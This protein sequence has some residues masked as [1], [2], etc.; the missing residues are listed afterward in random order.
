[1]IALIQRMESD[2]EARDEGQDFGKVSRRSVQVSR[3][4][5]ASFSGLVESIEFNA[6]ASRVLREPSRRLTAALDRFARATSVIDEWDRRLQALGIPV[7]LPT[8]YGSLKTHTPTQMTT[9]AITASQ[10]HSCGLP[11]PQPTTNMRKAPFW[12]Q[13]QRKPATT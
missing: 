4:A 12:A 11:K 1:M 5:M 8:G 13:R 10:T 3:D 9:Q 2:P 7:P 6:S